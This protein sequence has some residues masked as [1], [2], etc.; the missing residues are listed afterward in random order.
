[1]TPSALIAAHSGDADGLHALRALAGATVLEHQVRR[2]AAA[3]VARVVLLIDDWPPALAAPLAR[4]RADGIAV[5]ALR[6]LADAADRL[7]AAPRV[8][9]LADACLPGRALLD[10]LAEAPVPALA[11][12]TDTPDHAGFERIDAA[13]RWAGVALLDGRRIAEAAAMLGEWDP[14]STLLR[15][16]VQEGA[17]RIA[18]AD[19]PLMAG[20]SGALGRAEAGLVAASR[21]AAAGWADRW[22]VLPLVDALL[23]A[24]FRRR[25]EPLWPAALAVLLMPGGGLAAILGYRWP[26]LAALLIGAPLLRIATR[27]AAVQARAL[28]FPGL[29]RVVAPIGLALAALGLGRGLATGSGQW[30][31][32]LVAAS[33]PASFAA[34]AA[35]RRLLLWLGDAAEPRWRAR[36]SDMAWLLLPFACAGAWRTGLAVLAAW[37][38][39]SVAWV[40]RRAWVLTGPG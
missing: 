13:A 30:G 11:V 25:I 17:G 23:P 24:L 26:A 36:L 14:A 34:L 3:G 19:A 2:L 5:D 32:A 37:A 8:L 6:T 31:W 18:V 10:R 33:L 4:L 9:L 7:A 29:L 38:A 21:E 22:L 1:M 28:P 40:M 27:L 35:E 39:G 20:E 16:L 15:R 12:L